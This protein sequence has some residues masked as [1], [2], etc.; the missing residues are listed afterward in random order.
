MKNKK[1]TM[2]DYEKSPQ[3]MKADKAGLAKMD[4]KFEASKKKQPKKK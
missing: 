1:P 2:A 3:D 4:K